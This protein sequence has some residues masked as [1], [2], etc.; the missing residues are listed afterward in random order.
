MR[1]LVSPPL[2]GAETQFESRPGVQSNISRTWLGNKQ[3]SVSAAVGTFVVYAVG[4][5]VGA[6]VGANAGAIFGAS[7][8]AVGAVVRDTDGA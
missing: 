6:A 2:V 4:A 5:E 3:P 8:G 1:A 7:D